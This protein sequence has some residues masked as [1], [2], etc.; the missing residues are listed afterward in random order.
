MNNHN[1]HG[2]ID[3]HHPTFLESQTSERHLRRIMVWA[4]TRYWTNTTYWPNIISH[5]IIVFLLNHFIHEDTVLRKSTDQ[6]Y[7]IEWATACQVLWPDVFFYCNFTK[8]HL[9]LLKS[10]IV[11]PVCFIVDVICNLRDRTQHD[12]K[13]FI[14]YWFFSNKVMKNNY[15]NKHLS[16]KYDFYYLLGHAKI[17]HPILTLWHMQPSGYRGTYKLRLLLIFYAFS[18]EMLYFWILFSQTTI[19][20]CK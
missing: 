12:V 19:S 10:S 1:L 9:M 14:S 4:N 6:C 5:K 17:Q 2:A 15:S 11:T 20:K 13:C 16:F 8:I 18:W 7:C 3:T